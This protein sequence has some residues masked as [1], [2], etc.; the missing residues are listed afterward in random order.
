MD[1][2]NP[3]I[4]ETVVGG[5]DR[6]VC[7]RQLEAMLLRIFRYLRVHLGASAV[8]LACVRMSVAGMNDRAL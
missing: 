7:N 3:A 5:S 4:L 6:S 1:Q 2:N 8:R